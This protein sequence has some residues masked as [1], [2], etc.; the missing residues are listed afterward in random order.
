MSRVIDMSE[1]IIAKGVLDSDG[2]GQVWKDGKNKKAHRIAYGKVPKGLVIDH[3]CRNRACINTE[4]LE[5][6]TNAENIKRGIHYN[7][8]KTHCKNGHE[9]TDKNTYIRPDNGNR[10]CKTCRTI[11][12]RIGL[13]NDHSH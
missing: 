5:A 12:N 3:L 7:T 4:H 8:V 13:T 11:R 2:Y 9:F 10:N 6:V 1:C